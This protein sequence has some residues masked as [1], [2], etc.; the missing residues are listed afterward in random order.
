MAGTHEDAIVMIELSKW[1]TMLGLDEA[2]SSIWADDFDPE[3]AEA[4]DASIRKILAFEETL[5][6]LV[7]NGLLDRDLVYDWIWVRGIWDRVGPAALRAREEAG[8][9]Q[10]YE[11]FEA[12]ADGQP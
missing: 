1:G 8:I 9:P 10:L 3:T 6:T 4:R 12:L 7:K 2:M 11:N 5:A